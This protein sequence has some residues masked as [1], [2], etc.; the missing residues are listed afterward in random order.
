MGFPPGGD[1]QQFDVVSA[2]S[3][4]LF[5]KTFDFNALWSRV[6]TVCNTILAWDESPDFK[7]QKAIQ[8]VVRAYTIVYRLVSAP[9]NECP[10]LVRGTTTQ[11]D[12]VG[13]GVEGTQALVVY[14]LLRDMIRSWLSKTVL[15]RLKAAI[16]NEP[17]SLLKT[18]LKEWK[19]YIV[20]INNLRVVFSYL[21]GPWQKYGAPPEHPLL[22]TEVLALIQWNEVIMVPVITDPM[23]TEIFS[24][25]AKDRKNPLDGSNFAIIRELSEALGTLSDPRTNFYVA[26][27]EEPY[28]TLLQTFCQDNKP[29]KAKAEVLDYINWCLNLFHDEGIRAEQI[30]NKPSIPLVK[31]RMADVLI[32]KNIDYLVRPLDL[33]MLKNNGSGLLVLYELMSKS[34][35]GLTRFTETVTETVFR[36]GMNEVDKMC[37]ESQRKSESVYKAVLKGII[38]VDK[39]FE[40][41]KRAFKELKVLEKPMSDGLEKVLTNNRRIK[42]RAALGEELARLAHMELKSHGTSEDFTRTVH[43]I[44]LLFELLPLKAPFLES[45]PKYLGERLLSETFCETFE[46]LTIQKISE[47][48][49]CTNDF[50]HKCEVML[51]DIVENSRSLLDEFNLSRFDD[52]AKDKWVFN[53]RVLTGYMWT[54]ISAGMITPIPSCLSTK[55]SEYQTFFSRVRPKRHLTY[56]SRFSRGVVR[57]NLPPGPGLP[58][59]ELHIGQLQLL[60]TQYF[61]EVEEWDLEELSKII[62]LTQNDT[63]FCAIN[64]F[65]KHGIFEIYNGREKVDSPLEKA[66]PNHIIRLVPSPVT[67]KRKL[68]LYSY[69]WGGTTQNTMTNST[70]FSNDHVDASYVVDQVKTPA[71]QATLI[72]VF[73]SYG[74]LSFTQLLE[75]V[76]AEAPPQFV[77][78]V[79]QVK[80][81]LEFL[82]NRGFVSRSDSNGGEFSYVS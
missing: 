24:L 26:T 32:D 14:Y 31:Q 64:A 9:C 37:E 65:V 3:G 79:Q 25:I 36:K 55:L 68:L 69:E 4:S 72:R 82:I 78:T 11:E 41:I 35:T 21:H 15:H 66:L 12:V 34:N 13:N 56:V 60:L 74:T 6:S 17:S 71:I 67:R 38:S 54:G 59:I 45:Y 50:L 81:S 53:P 51:S 10:K 76:K 48:K 52:F 29:L 33:W 5:A 47:S 70:E 40:P 23:G 73:K 42:S 2:Y 27:I 49:G 62:S 61:N 39:F 8:E 58:T 77:P 80:M 19:T 22:P 18:Y 43:E 75:K 44:V 16:N 63:L 28:I 7:G 1:D 46:R 57:M 20:A 30:L